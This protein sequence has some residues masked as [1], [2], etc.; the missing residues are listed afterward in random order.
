MLLFTIETKGDDAL[1]CVCLSFRVGTIE[2]IDGDREAN[3]CMLKFNGY[4]LDRT[5]SCRGKY[6]SLRRNGWL[7]ALLSNPENQKTR[8]LAACERENAAG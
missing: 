4:P 7:Q 5:I 8:L 1:G 3:A 6:N 2:S